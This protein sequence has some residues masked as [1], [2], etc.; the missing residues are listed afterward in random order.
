MLAAG[1]VAVVLGPF[2]GRV[3]RCE[4]EGYPDLLLEAPF[5]PC[6]SWNQ[7][8]RVFGEGHVNDPSRTDLAICFSGG[9][10]FGDINGDGRLDEIN[11]VGVFLGHGDGVFGTLTVA[12]MNQNSSMAFASADL[13]RDGYDDV[14]VGTYGIKVYLGQAD[15]TLRE[16][17]EVMHPYMAGDVPPVLKLLDIDQDGFEDVL[18]VSNLGP[19]LAFGR[20]DGTFEVS[21]QYVGSATRAKLGDF[22]RDG[23]LDLVTTARITLPA[24]EP[25]DGYIAL[26]LSYGKGRGFNEPRTQIPIEG[27]D[28]WDDF[29]AGV[30]TGDLN[31]DGL[32]DVATGG[33]WG[34][35]AV[36][37]GNGDGTF[38]PQVTE[39][40]PVFDPPTALFFH[41][42]DL[43]G[44]G[45]LVVGYWHAWT[46]IYWGVEEGFLDYEHPTEIKARLLM[47]IEVS[48]RIRRPFL[49]GDANDDGRVNLSDGVT[50]LGQLF[51]GRAMV[52]GD[53]SDADDDGEVRITDAV[54][55]LQHLFLGGPE[56]ARPFPEAAGDPVRDEISWSDGGYGGDLGCSYETFNYV[57]GGY[58]PCSPDEDQSQCAPRRPIRQFIDVAVPE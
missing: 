51:L 52:C 23:L 17:E 5:R 6:R 11:E 8:R 14:L 25:L 36:F 28:Y 49:R 2:G 43:D 37:L 3:P 24:S 12:F 16:G 4:E 21:E 35:M 27:L 58:V 57:R 53:A 39:A 40:L 19:F 30:T 50:V 10:A 18:G 38:Q 32:L 1:L 29:P 7:G 9:Q 42:L 34:K 26:C 55:L 20:G 33:G 56:P 48:R 31:R 22:D 13:D 46:Q 45:D 47:N 15:G 44:L 54:Y 41:D